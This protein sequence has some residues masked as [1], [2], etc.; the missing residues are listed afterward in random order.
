MQVT[1]VHVYNL[2]P[3]DA[4]QQ[5]IALRQQL[6]DATTAAET[7]ASK[8]VD[9]IFMY[10]KA[11]G[12]MDKAYAKLDEKER[13]ALSSNAHKTV[14]RTRPE[15]IVQVDR[16][17]N[18]VA[19]GEE[20]LDIAS[21]CQKPVVNAMKRIV[22]SVGLSSAFDAEKRTGLKVGP[23][24][25]L[26]RINVKKQEYDNDPDLKSPGASYLFDVIRFTVVCS[27]AGHALQLLAGLNQKARH[28]EVVRTKNYF[29]GLDEVHYRR[30]Q[31]IVK[32]DFDDDVD[33]DLDGVPPCHLFEVQIHLK[34]LY[35]CYQANAAICRDPFVYFRSLVPE[36]KA[37]RKALGGN[38]GWMSLE[39][40]ISA[41][42]SFLRI[43]VLLAMFVVMLRA[44]D[45]SNPQATMSLPKTKP[46]LY[47]SEPSLSRL[48]AT[49]SLCSALQTSSNGVHVV[50]TDRDVKNYGVQGR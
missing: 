44:V 10:S 30:L 39:E 9:N 22:A 13:N 15:G 49:C 32:Y 2:E 29:W 38:E 35:D 20:L 40:R 42:E 45:F 8:L 37:M 41:W 3:Y 19:T 23:L 31:L 7:P 47:A 46:E 27:T 50:Q 21:V 33:V 14:D 25:L 12:K 26:E 1:T 6:C 48:H 5:Q 16:G 18:P 36:K 43:P 28:L 17:G 24:K 34:R 11:R 4:K